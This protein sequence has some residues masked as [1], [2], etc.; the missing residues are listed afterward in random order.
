MK[1]FWV[2]DKQ[3]DSRDIINEHRVA[4]QLNNFLPPEAEDKNYLSLLEV[5]YWTSRWSNP[6]EST[7]ECK[8]EWR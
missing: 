3:I 2:F 7:L 6:E 5:L 4:R 8:L 1:S